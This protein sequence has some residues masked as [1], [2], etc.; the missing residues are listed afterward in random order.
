MA[1]SAQGG[2]VAG[3]PCFGHAYRRAEGRFDDVSTD[4]DLR[5]PDGRQAAPTVATGRW[6]PLPPA[7]GDRFDAHARSPHMHPPSA[8]PTTLR[9]ALA[10]PITSKRQSL[11]EH[12]RIPDHVSTDAGTAPRLRPSG[13]REP[14]RAL[15]RSRRPAPSPRAPRGGHPP[16]PIQGT[17]V[18]FPLPGNSS[19]P[20]GRKPRRA[21]AEKPETG[22]S[23]DPYTRGRSCSAP[24]RGGRLDWGR[25]SRR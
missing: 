13:R 7:G 20:A 1:H 24:G 12:R 18:L 14:D 3:S 25:L 17:L 5:D 15:G 22:C 8:A 4:D 21:L 16:A 19:Q 10:P 2:P 9:T 11:R 6:R 23:S